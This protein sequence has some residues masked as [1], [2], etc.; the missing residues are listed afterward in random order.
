MTAPLRLFLAE[1]VMTGHGIDQIP[2]HPSNP[3]IFEEHATSALV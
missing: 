2:P 1:D 3:R